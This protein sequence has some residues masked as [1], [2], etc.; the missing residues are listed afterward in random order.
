MAVRFMRAR[1][2]QDRARADV[3]NVCGSWAGNRPSEMWE[4]MSGYTANK[5]SYIIAYA[6]KYS[7]F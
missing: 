5:I 6:H 4:G 3:Y 7:V 1:P 2:G